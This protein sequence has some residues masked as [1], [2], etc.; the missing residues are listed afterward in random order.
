MVSGGHNIKCF[1]TNARSLQSKLRMDELR[2]HEKVEKIDFLGIA[3][4]WLR[5]TVENS[6]IRIERYSLYRRDKDEI[7]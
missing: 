7:G 1:F 6:E 3:E 4:T 2:M 5:D